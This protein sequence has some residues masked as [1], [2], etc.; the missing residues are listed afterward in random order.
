MPKLT[1]EEVVG[2]HH[3][4]LS[5][6]RPVAAGGESRGPRGVARAGKDARVS[7]ALDRYVGLVTHTRAI[8]SPCWKAGGC[9]GG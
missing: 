3:K 9:A 8:L 1:G 7:V 6:P 2:A 5:G 4:E